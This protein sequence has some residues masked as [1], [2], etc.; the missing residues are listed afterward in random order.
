MILN[1]KITDAD[2]LLATSNF[3]LIETL[4]DEP[5]K[6]HLAGQYYDKFVF[7]NKTLKLA[8]RDVVY[9]SNLINSAIIYPI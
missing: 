3:I 4:L 2:T 5:S 1:T 9:D 6:L 8:R 7:E